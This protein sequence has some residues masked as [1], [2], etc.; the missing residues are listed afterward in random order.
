MNSIIDNIRNFEK[1]LSK[2]L[3]G[4][5]GKSNSDQYASV[6][7]AIS[8]MPKIIEK[9]NG[10]WILYGEDNLY[11][12]QIGDLVYGSSIHNSIIKTKSKMAAGDGLLVNGAV[13]L[14]DNE[15]QLSKLTQVEREE[16]DRFLENKHG[17]ASISKVKRLIA[18]DLEKY[19]AFCYEAIWNIDFTKVV[20]IKHKKVQ[21][22]RVGL[23]ENGIVKTYYYCKNWKDERKNKPEEFQAFTII[24][25]SKNKNYNQIYYEKIGDLDFYGEP[26]YIGALTWIQTDFQM[27]IFHLSNIENGLNPGMK[28]QF[29]K[30]PE[31]D[32]DKQ[33]ILR[34]IHRRYVGPKKASKH[35]VFFS[36]GK[37]NAPLIEPIATSNLDKQLLL[38]A[39]LCDKKILT[40]HQV[41]SPLIFGI[42]TAGQLGGNTELKT[43][44]QIFDNVVIADDRD[45]LTEALQI[46]LDINKSNIKIKINPFDPFK[47]KSVIKTKNNT[48]D[49]IANLSPP[50]A[51]KVLDSMSVDEIRELVGLDTK[52]ITEPI[53]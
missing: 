20:G 53:I 17:G 52:K 12:Y 22:I 51:N 1:N 39:E 18:Y 10:K 43:A 14:D 32:N 38:L 13:S 25:D 7:M 2:D 36:D 41:T 49:A 34:E 26:S 6:A 8:D 42:T 48:S 47:E 40:G 35:M 45:L 50:V 33:E 44:Y 19:G 16:Y 29:Y 11:P 31:T 4:A 5:K 24:N 15:I 27:G 3:S 46:P 9:P 30:L 28:M 21:N 37:E 23:V